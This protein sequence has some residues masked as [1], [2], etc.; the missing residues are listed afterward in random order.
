MEVN[1][2]KQTLDEIMETYGTSILKLSYSYVKSYQIAEEIT[3]EVFL[4]CYMK[5]DEF[6]GD[7]TLKTWLYRIAINKCKDYLKSW[8]YKYTIVTSQLTIFSGDDGINTPERLVML[9]EGKKHLIKSIMNLPIKYREVL[10][11]YYFE[12]LN[13]REISTLLDVNENTLKSRM[14]KSRELLK[15]KLEKGDVD[16]RQ[17]INGIESG[18]E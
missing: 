17:A 18:Y 3:Q 12:E 13:I 8:S 9:S 1:Y 6:K 7:S 14:I 10:F 2:K 5:L 15:S 11:L 4:T 16:V